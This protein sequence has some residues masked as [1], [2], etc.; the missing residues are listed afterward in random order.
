MFAPRGHAVVLTAALCAGCS[1]DALP[2]PG[3]VVEDPCARQ[4]DALVTPPPHTPRWAFE[5][6]I[7]KDISTTDDTYAFVEGFRE[8]DIPVG[9]VVLDS[10][11][12]T[13]Y[14]TFVPNPERYRDFDVLVS[15]M[16]AQDVRVVLWITQMVNEKSFDFESTGDLYPGASPNYDEALACG[17]FVNEGESWG[18]W[19]GVGGAMDFDHPSGTAWWHRQQDPL[20]D[21]GVDGFKLDFGDS[22]VRAETLR[23]FTGE[24]PHQHYSERY[25]EDYFAYGVSRRGADDFVTMVRA[26]DESYDLPGRFFARREHAPVAWM[27]DNRRD[28]I[29]LADALDHMLRS[30]EAGYPVVG[31]DIGGY[32][33]RDDK[34]IGEDVPFD[35]LVFARW[36]AV[37][38]MTPFM[39][40]HGRANL[41]PWTV[42]DHADET[43]A[44][45]R[46]WATLHH[47]L[48]PF[49]YSLA[50]HA[51]ADGG[52]TVHPVGPLES[53]AGDYRYLLGEALLVAPVLEASGVRDIALPEGSRWYDWWDAAGDPIAGGTVLAAYDAA[54]REVLPLF[55]RE[56]AIVPMDVG[57]ELTALGTAAS[58][59]H[60]TVLVYPGADP[61]QFDL[62][63]EDDSPTAI[64]AQALADRYRVSLAR[65]VRPT[66]LRVRTDDAVASVTHNGVAATQR[67]SRAE[68][69]AAADGWW[70][71]ADARV[72][73]VKVPA[74][75]V[76]S[77][78][79]LE[80]L[81]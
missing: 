15:D 6:W 56:G 51:W 20:F 58:A 69:D 22:Y 12:E 18:W 52:S 17:Y 50:Q 1:D 72:V 40:L 42:E 39:Q 41:A 63:E 46:Y 55:V 10:P 66:L 13:N 76:P 43:T 8:R 16:H 30:A 62:I 14:N 60:W 35:S 54:A 53:W 29:G 38:A 37:G 9:V 67:A 44:L 11:W 79:S 21:M 78:V 75:D 57:G 59:D 25:Y 31:S 26:W 68:L 36:T 7:S 34:N 24:V 32:L 73:W 48:V 64:D 2:V 65:T 45:Y 74:S 80:T 70:P 81:P 77:D 47:E 61:T 23:T 3:P 27:G 71:D 5:P 4:P 19:K 49:F 28:W 33:D